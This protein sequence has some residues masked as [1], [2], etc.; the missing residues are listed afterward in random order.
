MENLVT[1]LSRFLNCRSQFR[2]LVTNEVG[3][4]QRKQSVDSSLEPAKIDQL[5]L[6]KS[7]LE[8]VNVVCVESIALI[9][10]VRE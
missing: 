1:N 6:P 4:R 10:Q 5:V 7:G 3:D 8:R 9:D 2:V